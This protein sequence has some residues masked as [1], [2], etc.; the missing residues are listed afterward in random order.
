ML[1]VLDN[2]LEN[3]VYLSSS[4]QVNFEICII[5]YSHRTVK[6]CLLTITT[7]ANT[8]TND[9][10]NVAGGWFKLA[11]VSMYQIFTTMLRK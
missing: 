7:T 3:D 1:K 5:L 4:K 6:C 9:C 11:S 8:S 2:F 10:Q